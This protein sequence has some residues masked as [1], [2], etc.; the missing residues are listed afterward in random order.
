MNIWARI[1]ELISDG[2]EAIGTALAGIRDAVQRITNAEARRQVAFTIA[3]IALSAKMAK[4]DGV[5][6][7]DEVEAFQQIF[8]IPS[9]E[10]RNVSRIYNLA[11]N[12]V[13]GFEAY[14]GNVARL[15][16]DNRGLLED[17]LDGLFHIAKAD[18]LIHERELS[19]LSRVA[20]IFGFDEAEFA[21]FSERHVILAGGGDPYLVLGADRNWDY[22]KLK[23]HYR[24]LIMDNHPDRLV[25]RGVPEEFIHI[26]T[27]RVSAINQAW[28]I[29]EQMRG[30]KMRDGT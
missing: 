4:A 10:E 19:Y 21:R 7:P 29:I 25:A 18:G 8:T 3:M 23:K 5:V 28:D 9:G 11:K 27:E 15:F 13:A 20:E 30:E 24:K 12:D 6:T 2:T 16:P 1:G 14:A 22:E 17:I 26:A